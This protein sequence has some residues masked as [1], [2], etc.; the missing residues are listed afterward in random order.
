MTDHLNSQILDFRNLIINSFGYNGNPNLP[1]NLSLLP[2]SSLKFHRFLSSIAQFVTTDELALISPLS[3]IADVEL[4]LSTQSNHKHDESFCNLPQNH[5]LPNIPL[6][7]RSS[8]IIGVGTDIENVDRSSMFL[9][10]ES[11][12]LRSSL[13]HPSEI[14]HCLSASAPELSMLGIFCAKEAT[15]KACSRYIDVD[16]NDIVVYWDK[17]GAPLC[18]LRSNSGIILHISISH[19]TTFVTATAVASR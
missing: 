10:K 9:A 18:R 13:F 3:T 1:I 19:T 12:H 5:G 8:F 16:F 11:A 2:Y 17:C 7:N 14:L 6:L 4:C 15:I